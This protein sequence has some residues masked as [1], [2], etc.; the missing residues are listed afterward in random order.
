[1]D[2]SLIRV[3]SKYSRRID[4]YPPSRIR[5]DSSF[6]QTSNISRQRGWLNQFR[7]STRI[8]IYTPS[9][10][11]FPLTFKWVKFRERKLTSVKTQRDGN[12]IWKRV[13]AVHRLFAFHRLTKSGSW[14]KIPRRKPNLR[15]VEAG[16][17]KRLKHL[18][19]KTMRDSWR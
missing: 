6:V 14:N 18:C 7:T 19:Q 5:I 15:R 11:S 16:K 17:R 10:R 13:A 2:S 8:Y 3:I 12:P 4:P 1:M 9:T